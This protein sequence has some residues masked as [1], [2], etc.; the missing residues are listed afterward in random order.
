LHIFKASARLS[1]EAGSRY[2]SQPTHHL[3]YRP[4]VTRRSDEPGRIA[5]RLGTCCLLA[6]GLLAS[7]LQAQSVAEVQVT[8]ETMTLGVGQR[9]SIFAAAYDRQGNLIPTAQFAFRS[10]DT[11]VVRVLRDGVV[12]GVSPGLAR[13]EARVQGRRASMAVLVSGAGAN[14]DSAGKGGAPAGTVLTLEPAAITLLP[15]E[16]VVI[17]PQA[18]QENGSP[19][20]PG[21]VSWKSLRPEVASVDSSGLVVG[22]TPG[23]SVIQAATATRLMAT[24][25]VEVV[26]ADIALSRAQVVLGPEET[27]SIYA[28]VPSQSSRRIRGGLRWQSSDTTIVSVTPTGILLARA[29]GRAEIVATG[30]GQERRASA[31][32][33]KIAQRVIMTPRPTAEPIPLPLR[34][35]RQFSLAAEAADSSPIP[36]AR[37]TWEVGDSSIAGF[38]QTK[39][40]LTG[41]AIGTTTLTARLRGFDPVVW[42]VQVVSGALGLQRSRIGLGVG[43]RT[44]LGVALVD[45]Q[46]KPLS[47]ITD[48]EWTTD[49][50]DIVRV[51]P[52]GIVD[53]LK[54]GRA[55]V[56]GTAPW[57]KSIAAEVLVVADLLVAS[58]R[59]GKFGIYQ[60]RAAGGDTLSP[61]L[62]DGSA[63][64]QAVRSPDRTRIAFSSNRGGTYDLYLMDSDGRNPRPL[65]TDAAA[66]EGEP[67]WTP[68]GNRIVYTATP[69]PGPAQIFS[70]RVDGTDARPLTA[71]PGGNLSPAI[72]PDGKNIAFVS[73]RDGNQEIYQM[74]IDG[75][76]PRRITNTPVRESNPR[77]LPSGE[78]VF[79]VE[80]KRSKGSQVV[81]LGAGAVAGT[82]LAESEQPIAGMDISRDGARLAY[83]VGRL[84]DVAKNK[85]QFSLLIRGL[86]A[87]ATP[88]PVTLR[89]GEVVVSPSF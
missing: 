49:H 16:S 79:V 24:A 31:L 50:P 40:T 27:D 38:D 15:G 88:S 77:Y 44:T 57:G 39:G 83:V 81:R 12:L 1:T 62:V 32:V 70:I 64:V 11:L 3:G 55:L 29:P 80:R 51:S 46:L 69:R 72:S 33:H 8:P 28:L 87:A 89:P 71:A 4:P 52:G 10:S 35:T 22:V 66:D 9:Q 43:D 76:A 67:A 37:V 13:V 23:R 84:T 58:N 34:G 75:V 6:V 73:T 59:T 65:T 30:F 42:N 21:R 86:A 56:T 17:A 74:G 14:S 82:A 85:A 60:L 48:L 20:P 5:R 2:Y 41:R 18:F 25:P 26:P 53:G 68:D 7:D 63:N 45:E 47:P 78:L 61:V 54:P 36:E 19:V